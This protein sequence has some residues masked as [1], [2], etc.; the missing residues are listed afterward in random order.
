M[1]LQTPKASG[2]SWHF[3]HSLTRFFIHSPT[4]LSSRVAQTWPLSSVGETK[5]THTQKKNKAT[6]GGGAHWE[7]GCFRAIFL[8][9]VTLLQGPDGKE[10]PSHAAT[11]ARASRRGD[12]EGRASGGGGLA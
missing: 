11:W 12:D 10:G 2:S 7:G 8:E 1:P 6:A 9:K 4:E 3:M 5:Q